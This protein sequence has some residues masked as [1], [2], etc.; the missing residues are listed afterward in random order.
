MAIAQLKASAIP[1]QSARH[2]DGATA[3][4]RAAARGYLR[5]GLLDRTDH[6]CPA[7]ANRGDHLV[8]VVGAVTSLDQRH[9]PGACIR[10]PDSPASP[11]ARRQMRMLTDQLVSPGRWK[12]RS[13][14]KK[15][16]LDASSGSRPP[17]SGRPA[18]SGDRLCRVQTRGSLSWAW[19]PGCSRSYCPGH[20]TERS[21]ISG[22][23]TL[24]RPVALATVDA[25]RRALSACRCRARELEL[26]IDPGEIRGD[27]RREDALCGRR[28]KPQ[29]VQ[30]LSTRHLAGHRREQAAGH[31]GGQQGGQGKQDSG[32][33]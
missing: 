33:Q 5:L 26:I 27:Q 28:T 1:W 7:Q 14:A 11:K 30:E 18:G 32:T 24:T 3:A 10:F 25:R 23:L 6:T 21:P 29:T 9:S 4:H 19:C 13:I 22:L 16:N 2:W 20:A 15:A 12:E 8:V 17:G 31:E